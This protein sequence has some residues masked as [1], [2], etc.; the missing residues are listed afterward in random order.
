MLV[1]ATAGHVDHGKSALVRALT[2]MEPDRWAEERRRGM[3]IDLGYAWVGDITFVDVPGHARFIANML[4]GLGPVGAAMVV[5][6]ADD[7]WCAQ[8]EEHVRAIELLGLSH[9][10]GVVTRADLAAPE[11][12]ARQVRERLGVD[13]SVVSA[14]TGRGVRELGSRLQALAEQVGP[15]ADVGRPRLWVDRAFALAG[16][17]T[18]VTGTLAGGAVSAGDELTAAGRRVVV[19]GVHTRDEPAQIGRPGERVALRLRGADP[20]SLHRGHALVRPDQWYDVTALDVRLVGTVGPDLP[21]ALVVHVG[22]AALSAH[23]RLLGR[24]CARIS[25]VSPVPLQIGDRGLLRQPGGRGLVGGFEVIDVE[26]PPLTRRGDATRRADDLGRTT[27]LERRQVIRSA[28]LARADAAPEPCVVAGEWAVHPSAWARLR[29]AVVALAGSDDGITLGAAA[30]RLALPDAGVVRSLAAAAGVSVVDGRLQSGDPPLDPAVA[31]LLARLAEHEFDPAASTLPAA[32]AAAAARRGQ[33]LR[34]E[35]GVCLR[36]G[37]L[38]SAADLLARLAGPFSVGAARDALRTSRRVAVPVL[39]ALDRHGLTT[40][41][42]D[43]R[44][45]VVAD[46][47]E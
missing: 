2:G 6:A 28:D 45:S 8:T 12:A 9:L 38:T 37:A 46:Q 22:S 23:V 31:E 47:A 5:V 19:R 36:P 34:L 24:D 14:V 30:D 20:S 1:V 3:T 40:R 15:S 21:P 27:L 29:D 42:D 25:L 32:V 33:V 44:R 4:A 17:G 18:V 11:P 43:G 13:V 35:D 41:H 16:A 26:P 10:V 7:G 39:E